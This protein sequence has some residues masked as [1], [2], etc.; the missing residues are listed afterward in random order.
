MKTENVIERARR[1][2]IRRSTWIFIFRDDMSTNLNDFIEGFAA[3]SELDLA[4][5]GEQWAG[6]SRQLS[7]RE[8]EEIE[9]GG[10]AAGLEQGTAFRA[11]Y[12]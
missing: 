3:A 10:Y 9:A 12:A 5:A 8:R 7:D 11:L 2:A 4:E 6:F 1:S